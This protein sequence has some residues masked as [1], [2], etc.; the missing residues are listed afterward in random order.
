MAGGGW[1]EIGD[2]QARYGRPGG[3]HVA[4]GGATGARMGVGHGQVDRCVLQARR[5]GACC[6]HGSRT[7]AHAGVGHGED[8]RALQ[9]R[10]DGTGTC[11]R[12]G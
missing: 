10:L 9:A 8:G 5:T 12:H 6:R 11:C 4:G 2:R 3:R 7:G 1:R